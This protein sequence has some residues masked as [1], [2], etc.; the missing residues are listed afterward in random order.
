[1]PYGRKKSTM[2]ENVWKGIGFAIGAAVVSAGLTAIA[3]AVQSAWQK[4]KEKKALEATGST[5]QP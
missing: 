2:S 1:M 3:F 4:A 5:Y